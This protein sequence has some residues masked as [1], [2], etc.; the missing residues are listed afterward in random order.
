VSAVVGVKKA[1]RIPL[2]GDYEVV[3]RHKGEVLRDGEIRPFADP[4]ANR[5]AESVA[6]LPYA[7]VP[8]PDGVGVAK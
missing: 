5:S 2:S 1:F 6:E 3:R 8:A 7:D 4:A